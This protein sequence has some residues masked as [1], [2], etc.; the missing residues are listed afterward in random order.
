MTT[1]S[2]DEKRD[3][4]VEYEELQAK[5]LARK[6]IDKPK[7]PLWMILIPVFFVF[8]AWK[9]KE[10]KNGITTFSQNWMITRK[11][12]IDAARTAAENNTEPDIKAIAE[13]AMELPKDVLPDYTAWITLLTGHYLQL[14]TTDG[15]DIEGL[16]RKHFNNKSS[17]LLTL[18]QI[19]KAENSYHRAL[20]PA[21][22]GDQEDLAVTI[23]KIN[24]WSLQLQQE[25]AELLFH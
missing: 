14:L 11:R 22:P 5:Q 20:M 8:F 23:D 2:I 13:N 10:Y 19:S 4:I 3:L 17:Y 9:M 7:P 21:M 25:Q 24:K 12:C 18:K 15:K 16:L 6:I 1:L